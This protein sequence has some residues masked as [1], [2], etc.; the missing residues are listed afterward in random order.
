MA[1]YFDITYVPRCTNLFLARMNYMEQFNSP[2][3][4]LL[5][6]SFEGPMDP[7]VIHYDN[8]SYIWL[9]EDPKFHGKTK[10]INNNCNYIWELVQN[11]VL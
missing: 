4:K 3:R 8:T 10:H 6:D 2:S 11:G 7:T 9:S 5:S 1:K